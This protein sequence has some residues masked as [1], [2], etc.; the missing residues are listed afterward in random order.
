MVLLLVLVLTTLALAKR[1]LGQLAH[2]VKE[3]VKVQLGVATSLNALL[4]QPFKLPHNARRGCTTSAFPC[5]RDCSGG[6]G[7]VCRLRMRQR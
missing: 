7:L 3:A 1:L 6:T 5:G 2:D 4:K